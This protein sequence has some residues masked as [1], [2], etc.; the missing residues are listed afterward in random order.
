[1]GRCF[2]HALCFTATIN[3]EIS[4]CKLSLKE[5]ILFQR[6][7]KHVVFHIVKFASLSI[8]SDSYSTDVVKTVLKQKRMAACLEGI[9]SQTCAG[10]C[11]GGEHAGLPTSKLWAG[12]A[13]GTGPCTDWI[14]RHGKT[15]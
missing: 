4:I 5:S 12:G 7:Q 1:M 11:F 13:A 10:K 15:A 6:F 3:N 14:S 8:F 2:P 9:N